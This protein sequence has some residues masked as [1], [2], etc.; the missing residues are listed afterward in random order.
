LKRQNVG[1]ITGGK[2]DTRTE[3]DENA[4]RGAK[5]PRREK[6]SEYVEGGRASRGTTTQRQ[7]W[8]RNEADAD[9]TSHD[10]ALSFRQ[11]WQCLT[12]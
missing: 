8:Q 12:P 5:K 7:Q 1:K 6:S 4:K 10:P 3:S 2:K 9:S 11:V